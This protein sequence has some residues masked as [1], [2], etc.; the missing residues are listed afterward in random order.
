MD[1]RIRI[2]IHP[3]MSWIRNTVF[4]A[5]VATAVDRL[6]SHSHRLQ[7][8]VL[9]KG[10]NDV[11][12]GRPCEAVGPLDA[13]VG[14]VEVIRRLFDKFKELFPQILLLFFECSMLHPCFEGVT[15]NKMNFI[16]MVTSNSI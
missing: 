5:Y 10:E 1:P 12:L 6:N 15:S 4:K 11:R 16:T 3:K 13:G 9:L 7:D 8:N 14:E 2:R